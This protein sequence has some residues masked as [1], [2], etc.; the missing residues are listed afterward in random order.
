MINCL[1][2]YRIHKCGE[3]LYF[4]PFFGLNPCIRGSHYVPLGTMLRKKPEI[5]PKIK[6]NVP[7]FKPMKKERTI[8]DWAKYH[9]EIF[10]RLN[11][12]ESPK[13]LAHRFGVPVN[14]MR[15]YIKRY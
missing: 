5:K 1:K 12:G 15:Y 9:N 7:K 6:S 8:I 13:E 3:G 14:V 2:C 11:D 4:C 10:T